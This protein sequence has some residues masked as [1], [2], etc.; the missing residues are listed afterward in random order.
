[1]A[2]PVQSDFRK[3]FQRLAERVHRRHASRL[4]LT[5]ASVGLTLGALAA[6]GLWALRYGEW[7]PA[8]AGL[9]AL[10]ALVGAA[11]AQ[12][13]RWSESDVALYLDARLASHETVTTA[14]AAQGNA[15]GEPALSHVLERATSVL[16]NADP[17]RVRPELWSRV[18]ALLPAALLAIVVLSVLPLP[19][20]P[21]PAPSAPGVERI[22]IQNLKGLERIEALARLQGQNPQQDERLKNL[23]EQA[24]KLREALAKGLEKREALS[25]I[26]KL[27]DG[28]AAERLKL[29]DRQNRPGLDAALRAFSHHPTLRDAQKALGNGDL[30]AFDEEMQKLANRAESSDRRAAKDALEEAAKEARAKGAQALADALDAQKRLFE[31]RMAHAD[32]LRELAQSLKGKLSPEAL[33]DLKE[34]GNSG[35]PEAERRLADGLERALEGLTPEE[36]KRLAERMQKQLEGAD[37]NASPMTKKQLEDLAKQLASQDGI[38]QLKKQLQ[39]L[40]KPEPSDDAQR[41]QGL[42]DAERGGADA[43]RGLGTGAVPVP[44]DGADSPGTGS[45]GSK[46]DQAGNPSGNQSPNGAGGPGSKHD[47]GTGNHQGATP[48]IAAKELRSKADARVQ[49]GAPMHGA[50]LGRAPARPGETA[51]QLGTGS[52][53]D[54]QKTEVGAVDHADIPEEYRE[55]V[56]RY[57]EP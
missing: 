39:E 19:P 26:A 17:K 55:Q 43:E 37:G 5:G 45:P 52:L 25:E 50:T 36:R 12:R 14:L 31:R 13:K 23:A 3:A 1:M 24:K 42:G 29:A 28:I 9:G 30:T 40:A 34:F 18:H 51:N 46:P 33:E 10:G 6:L 49:A 54:A 20:A 56:G 32:A 57:F 53:G 8:A 11:L 16:G 41:E 38:E 44:L 15:D 47:S 21:V 2:V 22:Q 27:R 4:A 35:N 48:E 7:R